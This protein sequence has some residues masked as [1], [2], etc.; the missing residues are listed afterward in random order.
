MLP[1]FWACPYSCQV[2]L[3]YSLWVVKRQK[4]DL[5]FSLRLKPGKV[6][7]HQHGAS[8]VLAPGSC[9][10]AAEKTQNPNDCVVH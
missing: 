1:P 10:T 3:V 5:C 2:L 4:R 6:E 9:H 7:R 8:I